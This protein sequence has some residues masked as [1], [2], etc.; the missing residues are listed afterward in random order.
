M[1]RWVEAILFVIHFADGAGQVAMIAL[2]HGVE[3][4]EPV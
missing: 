3:I 1:I 2:L 4:D